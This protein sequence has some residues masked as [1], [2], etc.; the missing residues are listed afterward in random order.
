MEIESGRSVNSNNKEGMDK[1]GPIKIPEKKEETKKKGKSSEPA[2]PVPVA[3]QNPNGAIC[4]MYFSQDYM[5]RIELFIGYES[6]AI[7]GFRI[8]FDTLKGKLAYKQ[9]LST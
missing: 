4:C 3:N 5:S 7:G 1:K 8:Y 2:N 9:V 6:G